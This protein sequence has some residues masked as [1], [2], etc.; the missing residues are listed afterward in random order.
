MRRIRKIFLLV[1]ISVSLLLAGALVLTVRYQEEIIQLFITEINK[2][3]T[4]PV[5]VGRVDFSVLRNFPNVS[6]VIDQ[7]TV[8]SR[9]SNDD[10]KIAEIGR[11]FFNFNLFHI[12]NN[13]I[14]IKGIQIE[15]AELWLTVDQQGSANYKIIKEGEGGD[16]TFFKLQ[17]IEFLRTNVHYANLKNGTFVDFFTPETR[18]SIS[19]ISDITG[20]DIQGDFLFEGVT[21]NN[22]T[23]FEQK[24]VNI[25]TEITYSKSS[26]MIDII[27]GNLMIDR[28]LFAMQGAIDTRE[29]R[30]QLS[31]KGE[32]T[33]F[34]TLISLLPHDLSSKY[35]AYRSKG[36]V[37]FDSEVSGFYGR[38]KGID[39]KVDF[40]ARDAY[41]FH[42]KYRKGIENVNFHGTFHNGASNTPQTFQLKISDISCQLD[43][44]DIAG[45]L[46]Y[47][48]FEDPTVD[49]YLK[50]LID[51]NSLLDIFPNAIIKSAYGRMRIDLRFKGK[52]SD[53]KSKYSRDN[54]RAEGEVTLDNLSFILHGERLPFNRFTGSF[55]FN[56]NDLAISN[57]SGKVG[58][59]DFTLHGFFKSIIAYSFSKKQDI[60]IEADLQSSYLDFDELL[61]SNFASREISGEAEQKYN[62]KI[63]PNLNLRF[64]CK[65]DHVK[66]KRFQGRN[67]RG[68]V[69]IHDR[70]AIFN[71]LKL[72][73]MGGSIDLTGSVSNKEWNTV[74]LITDAQL[75]QLHID[76]V[77]FVFGN[78]KQNW[79]T[80]RNLKGQIY[81][82]VNAYMQFNNHLKLSRPT[83][84]ADIRA[85]IDNGAL[86]D[87]EPMQ[88]LSKYVEEEDLAHLTFSR[89][90]NDIK[91]A[92]MV[93]TLPDMEISSHIST[94]M[95]NG[96]HTF[97]QH[98]DYHLTLPLRSF[99]NVRK[100]R[101]FER[102]AVDG[103]NLLLKITGTTKDYEIAYD[104]KALGDKITRDFSDEGKEWKEIIRGDSN[105]QT[106]VTPEPEEEEYFDFDN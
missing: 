67:I 88:R 57:F 74:E 56:K 58:N 96:T 32:K 3:L 31:F 48:N 65:A 83:L 11:I 14:I 42:P 40:G 63:S 5:A 72:D 86:I 10:T 85:S 91:I 23:Y 22:K 2:Q 95:I 1:L 60:V 64:N 100:R 51:A 102:Q 39:V 75:D 87:F 81:A 13:K 26:G 6:I 59:S 97:D 93:I 76:S 46:L 41:F 34:R 79:L 37:F 18:A 61:E 82:T 105:N 53:L 9:E 92:D 16:S 7:A 4:A 44:K 33:N 25:D 47:S 28:G 49:F 36:D 38:S 24:K 101:D 69:S 94:L 12:I 15:D 99:I 35:R 90:Q 43:G 55:I 73:A 21:N 19:G 66:F 20:I 29:Q 84:I 80:D 71:E 17:N 8:S 98:I 30:L 103:S 77:F 68:K 52:I 106:G 45:N 78:F 70:I 27:F 50:G 62:F 89:M 54:F 104:R